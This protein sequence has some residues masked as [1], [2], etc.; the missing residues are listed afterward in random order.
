ML[1][2]VAETI[3]WMSRYIERA[4]NVARFLMVNLNQNLDAEPTACGVADQASQWWPLVS[5]MGDDQVYLER[6]GVF[7]RE[8]VIQFLT[9][10]EQNPNSIAA[11]LQTARENA[12]SVRESISGEMWQHINRFYL[13]V[14]EANSDSTIIENPSGFYTQANQF[15]QQFVGVSDSTMT[16]GEAWQFCQL[17]HMLERADMT[18]RIVDVKYFMLLPSPTDV[19]TNIDVVQWSALLRSTSAFE[20]YRQRHG[21]IT[22]ANVVD[23]LILDELFPRA[24]RHCLTRAESAL[25]AITGNPTPTYQQPVKLVSHLVSA[26]GRIESEYV[27]KLGLHEFIDDLQDRMNCVGLSVAETFFSPQSAAA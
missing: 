10:D 27:I 19:G 21:C 23:F 4:E 13:M 8:N 12:R 24:V 15:G 26:L 9:F 3:Y 14:Q 5:T 22:P 11:C 16:H 17:G 18:T 7:S 25:Q 1:S 20:M 2:R 6:F